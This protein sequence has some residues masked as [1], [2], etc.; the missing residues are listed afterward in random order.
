[1]GFSW[2]SNIDNDF[3]KVEIPPTTIKQTD[4]SNIKFILSRKQYEESFGGPCR[5][6]RNDLIFPVGETA[7]LEDFKKECLQLINEFG[8]K[9]KPYSVEYFEG[10]PEQNFRENGKS[11]YLFIFEDGKWNFYEEGKLKF[12]V[13]SKEELLRIWR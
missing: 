7:T 9:N 12:S 5:L 1:M 13:K 10:T 4:F 2:S 11:I 8:K 3:D 6:I